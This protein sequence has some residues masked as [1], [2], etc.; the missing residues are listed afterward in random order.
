MLRAIKNDCRLNAKDWL[1]YPAF[2][3][4]GFLFGLILTFLVMRSN[5]PESWFPL[6]SLFAILGG[7]FCALL[8][9]SIAFLPRYQI[10]LSMGCTRKPLIAAQF[11][12]CAAKMA[13]CALLTLP[14]LYLDLAI[15]RR[16]YAVWPVELDLLPYF[17]TP[18]LLLYLLT[19]PCFSL[20]ISGVIGK[21]GRRGGGVLY[22]IFL[23]C[24]IGLPRIAKGAEQNPD[25]WVARFFAACA[26]L[27]AA[28]WISAGAIL[29]LLV[30]LFS[31]RAMM[32]IRVELS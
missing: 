4:G 27:P 21:F 32:T 8:Y 3:I 17:R 31:I 28:L 10:A 9:D 24:C 11:L 5:D 22:F 14:L 20:L 23:F 25:G 15:Y 18:W 19:P 30:L 12:L 2:V 29:L 6:A 1:L 26:A 16:F 7:F 13:A